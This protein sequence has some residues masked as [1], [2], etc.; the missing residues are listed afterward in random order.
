MRLKRHRHCGRQGQAEGAQEGVDEQDA[1]AQ[2]PEASLEASEPPAEGMDTAD[3]V[4]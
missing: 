1:E 2:A 4:I 3:P